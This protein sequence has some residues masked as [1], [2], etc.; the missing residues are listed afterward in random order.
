VNTASLRDGVRFVR[1]RLAKDSL[2][3][4]PFHVNGEQEQRQDIVC[5]H[6]S[7]DGLLG[8][9]KETEGPSRKRF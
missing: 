8:Y 4:P 2:S 5:D 7:G 3:R 1:R 9:P 6:R